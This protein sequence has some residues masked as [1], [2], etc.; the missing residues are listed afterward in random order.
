MGGWYSHPPITIQ[1]YSILK[2]STRQHVKKPNL[3]ERK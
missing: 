1:V 3:K 2:V